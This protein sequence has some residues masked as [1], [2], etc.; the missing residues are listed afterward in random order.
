MGG[1]YKAPDIAAANREAVLAAI[2]TFPLQREIEA[3]SRIGETVNVK[4]QKGVDTGRT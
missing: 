2:E 3:A 4:S 1:S